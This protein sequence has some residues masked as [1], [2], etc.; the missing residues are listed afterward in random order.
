MYTAELVALTDGT[1]KGAGEIAKITGWLGA[2]G[3]HM[4]SLDSGPRNASIKARRF[5]AEC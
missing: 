3:V 5:T 4:A 2:N 1:V